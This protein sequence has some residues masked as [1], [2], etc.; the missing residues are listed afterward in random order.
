MQFCFVS[1]ALTQ[2]ATPAG[3]STSLFLI[4]LRSGILI[5][6]SSGYELPG[7]LCE[8]GWGGVGS[9]SVV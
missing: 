8:W 5:P 4:F 7:G 3:F 1:C 6:A 9:F 2:S